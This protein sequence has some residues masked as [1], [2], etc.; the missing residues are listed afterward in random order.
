M[1]VLNFNLDFKPGELCNLVQ[2]TLFAVSN[3]D[4]VELGRW[5]NKVK[6]VLPAVW[7]GCGCR[8]PMA[9]S[10]FLKLL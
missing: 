2:V 4:T 6:K 10:P 9:A 1:V 3:R 8:E 7:R 5:K